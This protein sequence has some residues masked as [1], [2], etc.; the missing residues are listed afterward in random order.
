MWWTEQGSKTSFQSMLDKQSWL[1]SLRSGSLQEPIRAALEVPHILL[2]GAG[3]FKTKWFS[4]YSCVCI[5]VSIGLMGSGAWRGP[6][7]ESDPLQLKLQAVVGHPLW[8]LGPKLRSSY[9]HSKGLTHWALYADWQPICKCKL[10]VIPLPVLPGTE[11]ELT[12]YF[13]NK[14]AIPATCINDATAELLW[15]NLL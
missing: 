5:Y 10:L 13:M 14:W 8:V 3:S 7:R 9:L 6:K 4:F 12:K 1:C 15:I 11:Q 2:A